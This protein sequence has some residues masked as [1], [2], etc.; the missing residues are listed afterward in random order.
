MSG[1]IAGALMSGEAPALRADEGR[2]EVALTL[3]GS[4][5]IGF[6]LLSSSTKQSWVAL[7]CFVMLSVAATAAALWPYVQLRL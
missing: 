3:G 2:F 4:E 6:R 1:A 5:V 7:M